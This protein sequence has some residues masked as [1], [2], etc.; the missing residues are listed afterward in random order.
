MYAPVVSRLHTYGFDVA[1]GI[2]AYMD[3]VLAHPAFVSWRDD[4]YREPWFLPRY[5]EDETARE[6][7]YRP[8]EAA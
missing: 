1:P 6:V 8:A 2:R 3:A 7:L 5:E 4:A